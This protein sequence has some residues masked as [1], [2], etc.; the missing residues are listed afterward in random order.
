MKQRTSD[1]DTFSPPVRVVADA[2]LWV[3]VI[4][5][6]IGLAYFIVVPGQRMARVSSVVFWYAIPVLVVVLSTWVLRSSVER[7]VAT[8]LLLVSVAT[9]ALAA[10]ALLRAFPR[11]V[12][13][14]SMTVTV[15]DS[16]CPGEFRRQAGCLAAA[17][18]GTP[19]DRRTT[20]EVIQ[21]FETQGIEA[22][23]SLDASH[24]IDSD[25]VIEIDG[26]V[27]VPLSPGIPGALTT[28]CNEA[29]SWVSYHADEYGFNN[30]AGS[31][32][33]GEINVAIVGDSFVHGWCAPF[34]QTLTGRM[35]QLDPN[36]LGV[37]LEGSGPLMQLGIEVEYLAPL[38]PAVVVWVFFEGNDLRDFSLE[39]SDS[40]LQRYLDPD[41]KQGL[42]ELRS[43]L[44]KET[45]DL[46]RR[47]RSEEIR[48]VEQKR[49]DMESARQR[50]R[51]LA[52]WIRLTEV[53]SRLK[54][55]GRSRTRAHPYDPVLFG[56]VASRMRD[57]VA[58]WGG[59]LLFVSLPSV[60]RFRDPSTAN[61][62]RSSILTQVSE[63]GIPTFDFFETLSQHPDPLSLFPFRLEN[64]LT[65]EGYDL[66]ARALEESIESLP[67][68]SKS[69]RA[70][71]MDI[72]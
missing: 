64:H 63:L 39:L 31:H 54:Y 18:A 50:R 3:A 69:T 17:E 67:S 5:F 23:P 72:E 36:V 9:S 10:E 52:G 24:Y 15:A 61:P 56:Q 4:G 11:K 2:I 26:R 12:A 21:D 55:L 25:Y 70:R 30:P 27:V 58:G 45:R 35:R 20:L 42:R 49:K 53:R 7:R 40:L 62:H 47:L 68:Y 14:F 60:R 37:G 71:A 6:G 34:A 41:F 46:I 38:R 51:S 57:D 33:P 66:M 19:F 16:V 28:L 8:A 22:W 29:G 43:P 48:S 44:E 59:T 1:T 13:G 32:R 65:A